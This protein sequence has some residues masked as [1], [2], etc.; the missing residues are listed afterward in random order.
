MTG[1]VRQALVLGLALIA[2]PVAAE[3]RLSDADWAA[4]GQLDSGQVE[5]VDAL[6]A[7]GA[8]SSLTFERVEFKAQGAQTWVVRDGRREVLPPTG[9]VVLKGHDPRKPDE[10]LTLVIDAKGELASGAVYGHGGLQ[11]IRTYPTERGVLLR[12]YD[13]EDLLPDGVTLDFQCGN[14]SLRAIPGYEIP[15]ALPEIESRAPMPKSGGL[16]VGVLAIDTDKEWLDRRFGDDLSAANDWLEQLMAV[17]N[18]IFERD[19]NLRMLLGDVILRVGSDPYTESG[20]ADG[21]ALFEFGDFWEAN[22]SAVARTHAALISGRSGSGNSASGIAWVNSYCRKFSWGGSY[23]V[24][25]LF[26]NSGISVDLSARIFAHELG[27]NLGSSHTHCYDPPVDQCYAA[28]SG[29]YTGPTSC[30]PEGTG[31][32][33]SYCH[34]GGCGSNRLQ[35]HPTVAS[36]IQG[37]IQANFPSCITEFIDPNA[38]EIFSDRF[39]N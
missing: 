23:S 13:P 26:Y 38:G 34:I 1:A 28:E 2:G 6:K 29:C 24:N 32:L 4:L 15:G 5:V 33:M 8:V 27:H 37:R 19:L 12:V 18:G 25:R 14:D 30:P 17:T 9:Q 11:P 7:R 3:W 10:S 36:R 16:R 21:E 39:E 35:L 22:L 20:T 31:S